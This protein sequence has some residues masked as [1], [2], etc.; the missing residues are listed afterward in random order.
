MEIIYWKTTM[1]N[2]PT[3]HYLALQYSAIQKTVLRHDRL[4]SM[5]GISRLLSWLN[6]IELPRLAA[7]HQGTVLVAGGGKFTARFDTA[8]AALA[9]RAGAIQQMATTLPMLEFQVSQEPVAGP[10]LKDVRERL[11]RDDV[12]VQKRRVRGYGV[13]F[14][15]H[16]QRCDECG[17][18]P[19][20]E[21]LKLG[22]ESDRKVITVCRCCSTA[23]EAS[24]I[25]LARLQ[26][27][28]AGELTTIE[29]VYMDYSR[30]VGLAPEVEAPLNFEDLFPYSEKEAYCTSGEGRRRM[31]V[32]CS[33]I[34]NMNSKVPIWLDQADD[35]IRPTFDQV[36]ALFVT[37]LVEAL[38]QTGFTPNQRP[39]GRMSETGTFLPF[40][41]IVVGGDDLCLVMDE[42]YILPFAA[43][44]SRAVN[45]HIAGLTENHPLHA[46]WLQARSEGRPVAPYSFGAAF[47]ITPVHTPFSRIHAVGEDLMS[48]A[49]NATGR[50]ANSLN[51]RIMAET[52]SLTEQVLAFERPLFIDDSRAV[53]TFE[54]RLTFAQYL[55]LTRKYAGLSGSH[56]QQLVSWML[57]TGNDSGELTFRMKRGAA[58]ELEKSYS[59]L[60]TEP[61][62][63]STDGRINPSRLATLLELLNLSEKDAP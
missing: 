15:P 34:N 46:Q 29:R 7:R 12:A 49:K 42:R 4:W 39:G 54:A 38:K 58:A 9:F 55:T 35:Q 43:A 22:R 1:P 26:A 53:G 27:T 10:S 30:A 56:I 44:L 21:T 32:W 19:A 50:Q 8:E 28:E 52:D 33:D 59:S 25:R 41:L 37:A 6:E 31:A 57:S 45:T 36:K 2:T 5:A 17:E 3:H 62:L 13:T 61:D 24:R 48:T 16:L 14:N 63:Q 47:I 11:I 40:R 23:R 60:L 18:Y 51:W 20:E